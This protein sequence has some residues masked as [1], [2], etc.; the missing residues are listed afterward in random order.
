MSISFLNSQSAEI[1]ILTALMPSSSVDIEAKGP[2][3]GWIQVSSNRAAIIFKEHLYTFPTDN[4]FLIEIIQEICNISLLISTSK[5][6]LFPLKIN[7]F[8]SDLK[9]TLIITHPLH[10]LQ[11]L[12]ST[13]GYLKT[14]VLYSSL[15]THISIL[16]KKSLLQHLLPIISSAQQ[17]LKVIFLNLQTL[18]SVK[19]LPSSVHS[20]TTLASLAALQLPNIH[21]QYSIPSCSCTE[22]HICF[23]E[24]FKDHSII[25]NLSPLLRNIFQL[26]ELFNVAHQ[27]LELQFSFLPNEEIPILTLENSLHQ[28]APLNLI[29]YATKWDHLITMKRIVQSKI[30]QQILASSLITATP[31]PFSTNA[32]TSKLL[33][34]D[35]Y[36]DYAS[37]LIHIGKNFTL[38]SLLYMSPR[39][40][41]VMNVLLQGLSNILMLLS[42][43]SHF[44]PEP[45]H[46]TA[47]HNLNKNLLNHLF[48]LSF[49]VYSYLK[50]PS[51]KREQKI[52]AYLKSRE[53]KTL[54]TLNYLIKVMTMN[55]EVWLKDLLS[56][57]ESSLKTAKNRLKEKASS[58]NMILDPNQTYPI[59]KD[60]FYSSDL[61]TG[62]IAAVTSAPITHSCLKTSSVN[63]TIPSRSKHFLK[64]SVRFSLNLNTH[65]DDASESL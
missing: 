59:D 34:N 21:P 20:L 41:C 24:N 30:M 25:R 58:L 40:N 26:N 54:R 44:S 8:S 43:P 53:R 18:S 1:L 51:L 37:L 49:N 55:Q 15:Q 38:A 19:S 3:I 22:V 35:Q 2:V 62:Y 33:G 45:F 52:L 10:L 28:I 50:N 47:T 9:K 23:D 14:Q 42:Q 57:V 13:L 17:Q 65:H 61:P 27:Y 56:E 63:S 5:K 6:S 16:N 60:L 7:C 31:I 29:P 64:S 32:I 39:D 48:D 46:G 11:L 4:L 12:S 36:F